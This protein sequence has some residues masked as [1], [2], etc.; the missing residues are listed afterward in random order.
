M[1]NPNPDPGEEY[2]HVSTQLFG[3][4]NPDDNRYKSATAMS[5][6]FNTPEP[7]PAIAP[8]NGFVADYINNFVR[9]EHRI[10]T[11]DEYRVIM[12]SYTPEAVPVISTL[13][14]EFAVC[15]RWFCDVPS[16]TF[17]NRAFFHAASSAAQ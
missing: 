8:M 2:P 7:T 13:A 3:T 4:V 1:D 12:Q 10:P 6:P 5:E 9:T 11:Y 16:Q 15:D 14:R 17:A